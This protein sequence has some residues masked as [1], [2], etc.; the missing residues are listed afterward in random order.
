MRL[1]RVEASSIAEALRLL[2]MELGENALILHTK[3]VPAGGLGGRFRASRVEVLGAIEEPHAPTVTSRAAGA[4]RPAVPLAGE[5]EIPPSAATVP[6]AED[7]EVPY[8]PSVWERAGARPRRV[9]FVG[10]TGAGKTTT[11]AKV[12]A[13]AQLE[14][15]R[16]VS[17]VTIDTYRIGAV[18]QL[19][20][21]ASILGVPFA[22]A[23]TPDELGE[24]LERARAS[25]LVYIDTTG[26][27]P[28]G[29]GIAELTPF[30][31]RAAADD[32]CLV[33]S[34]TTRPSD[35]L[36]AATVYQRLGATRLC[37]TKLDETE[38][39]AGLP[40]LARATGLPFTWLGVGQDVPDDLEEA[41][42][43]RMRTL[44]AGSAA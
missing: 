42:P 38:D 5:P 21:Y 31:D 16:R 7:I 44:F 12:A 23:R 24:A 9:A 28:R 37:I 6:H 2:R 8:A 22:V 1:K 14:H 36:R 32:V 20:S 35:A 11:L 18:P 17:V 4:A 29:A 15:G 39:C 13:R 10:P 26:R 27:S 30:L 41:E 19:E 43:T 34:A 3:T 25:D 33:I 40:S